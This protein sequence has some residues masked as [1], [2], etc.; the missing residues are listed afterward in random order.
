MWLN[1]DSVLF[2]KNAA[3]VPFGSFC[4]EPARRVV[5]Y[6]VS[7]GKGASYV[8]VWHHFNSALGEKTQLVYRLDLFVA[9]L[10][11]VW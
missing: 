2:M 7:C 8:F 10:R 11:V 3:G 6:Y 5:K 1:F 9:S 4:R